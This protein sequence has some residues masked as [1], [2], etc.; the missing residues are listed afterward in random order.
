MKLFEPL[1][2]RNVTLRNRIVM[3]PMCMHSALSGGFVSDFHLV[4]YGARA[5]GGVG[6]VFFETLA[7]IENGMIGPGDLG[8]WSDDHIDG[9]KRLVQVVQKMGAKA[10]A[11]IGHA[12]RLEGTQAHTAI[13]PSAIAFSENTLVPHEL[14]NEEI[15]NIVHSFKAAAKRVRLAGFDILE[16]HTA[17][18]YLLNEFLSPLANKR[19]DKWGGSH[20][21]RY[22]IVRQILDEVR[23][24]W[25]GPLFVRISSTDYA[26]GGNTPEDFVIY[27][28]WM[29]EQGVD[30]IDCSSGGIAPADVKSFPG[31][32]V[33]AATLLREKLG[34]MTGA[35]GLIETGDLAADIIGN[36]RA[37]LVF[38]GRALLR[39]PFWP[40]TA[41]DELRVSIPA[42]DQYTR[43]G[44][45]WLNTQPRLTP[46]LPHTTAG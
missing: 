17:H 23:Q 39:D 8:I 27:G 3:S 5:L 16:I 4:H 35:V 15:L 41:A 26:H 25:D 9:L 20:E 44:A 32:Q 18:G 42:P 40:R 36:M 21:N 33:A 22:R 31:Y 37:D 7:T 29:K 11:Q 6:L 13:A 45:W 24:E 2:L 10:G 19:T 30:L 43:Y 14:T 1:T 12:G 28:Q 46:A 34:I 38:I